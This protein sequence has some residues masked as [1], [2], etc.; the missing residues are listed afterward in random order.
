MLLKLVSG[1][2]LA[3]AEKQINGQNEKFRD[4][5]ST[6]YEKLNEFS[7]LSKGQVSIS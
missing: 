2:Q 4:G 7:D 6:F 1:A 5:K 3:Q